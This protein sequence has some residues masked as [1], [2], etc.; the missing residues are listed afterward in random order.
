[1]PASLPCALLAAALLAFACGAP[2]K[3]PDASGPKEGSSTPASADQDGGPA[4]GAQGSDAGSPS[5]ATGTTMIDAGSPESAPS[6]ARGDIHVE[7]ADD[8]CQAAGAAFE[9]RA[10]PQIKAC[11]REAKKKDANLVGGVRITVS[12]NSAGKV[13]AVLS[14][15]NGDKKM[16]PPAVVKCMVDATKAND[17]GDVGLCKGKSLGIPVQFPSQ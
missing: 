14:S 5:T 9:K 3:A 4:T 8:A 15:P 2:A 13:G 17:P 10:R 16:L 12:I 7:D 1:M 11:Y 6:S